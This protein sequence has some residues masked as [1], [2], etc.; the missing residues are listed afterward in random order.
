MKFT[1]RVLVL[2]LTLTM[3]PCGF[4]EEE[5]PLHREMEQLNRQYRTLGRQYTEPSQQAS[6]LELVEA[7]QKK[8]ESMKEMIPAKASKKS[9]AEK[10]A[11]LNT[12]ASHMDALLKQL[13]VLKEAISTGNASAAKTEMEKITTLKNESHK[14]LG[15]EERRKGG[16]SKGE[17]R[18][19]PPPGSAF[20]AV[21]PSKDS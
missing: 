5:D 16:R 1:S 11:Y 14:E 3:P 10:T 21:A 6:S 2:A 8:V 7:M 13:A 4:G 18:G 20:D 9:G 15:V 17:R 12:Y 19:G